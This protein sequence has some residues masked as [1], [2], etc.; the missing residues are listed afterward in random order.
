MGV[1]IKMAMMRV[2]RRMRGSATHVSFGIV[3]IASLVLELR[4]QAGGGG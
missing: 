2:Y 4:G 3:P 1:V